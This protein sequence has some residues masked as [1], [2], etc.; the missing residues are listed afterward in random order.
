MRLK[1]II[2][3]FILLCTFSKSYSQSK[4]QL[5]PVVGVGICSIYEN[6]DEDFRIHGHT[7]IIGN[8]DIN[9]KFRLQPALVISNK[10]YWNPNGYYNTRLKLTYLD[11]IVNMKYFPYK[12]FF[13]GAG[14]QT[15]YLIRSKYIFLA[16]GTDYYDTFNINETTNKLDIG[17]SGCMGFQFQNRVGIELSILYGLRNIFNDK[18]SQHFQS[19]QYDYPAWISSKVQ[20][21]N[22]VISPSFY[23]LISRKKEK[24]N[25]NQGTIP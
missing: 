17:I 9:K 12:S 11:V 21:K 20:G 16:Y 15:G 10:G 6:N 4:I 18:S 14:L 22:V 23:Y 1:R 5:G 2:T 25:L 3:I 7:G 24:A 8:Y 19:D 13:I